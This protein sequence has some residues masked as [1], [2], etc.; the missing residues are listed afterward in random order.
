MAPEPQEIVNLKR[1]DEARSPLFALVVEEAFILVRY[2]PCLDTL[3]SMAAEATCSDW[4][5]EEDKAAVLATHPSLTPE[6]LSSHLAAAVQFVN[7]SFA[8]VPIKWVKTP[9][10]ANPFIGQ[11]TAE[12]FQSIPAPLFRAFLLCVREMDPAALLEGWLDLNPSGALILMLNEPDADYRIYRPLANLFSTA[13]LGGSFLL[14]PFHGA[15]ADEF[16]KLEAILPN[17]TVLARDDIEAV[18][19]SVAQLAMQVCTRENAERERSR[20]RKHD[21]LELPPVEPIPEI[22]PEDLA[23]EARVV[24]SKGLFCR[25]AAVQALGKMLDAMQERRKEQQQR[26]AQWQGLATQIRTAVPAFMEDLLMLRLLAPEA[27]LPLYKRESSDK[28]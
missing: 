28:K 13:M 15:N 25:E 21:V 23:S 10:T 24:L 14:S 8:G 1:R 18:L 27:L 5:T 20:K 4:I 2:R 22:S 3:L 7:S 17:A 9:V 19:V 11:I 6:T 12:G 26:A 16:A